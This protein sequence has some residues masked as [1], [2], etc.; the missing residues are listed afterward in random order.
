MT[1]PATTKG[2]AGKRRAAALLLATGAVLTA[3]GTWAAWQSTGNLTQSVN[4]A[5]VTVAVTDGG[6]GSA[7]WSTAIDDLLPGDYFYRWMDVENTGS[8]PQTFA[9]TLAGSGTLPGALTAWVSS[10]DVAYSGG[11]STTCSGTSANLLGTSGAPA[12]FGNLTSLGVIQPGDTLHLLMRVTFAANASQVTY[13][14]QASTLTLTV[15]GTATG[16]GDRT[17]G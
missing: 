5:T 9:G 16:L 12:A 13:E 4:T 1:E 15:T 6:S 8:V 14:N 2:R 17:N 7:T 3:T 10:C 11:S